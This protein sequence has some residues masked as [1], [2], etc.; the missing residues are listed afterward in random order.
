MDEDAAAE[1]RTLSDHA[2]LLAPLHPLFLRFCS[3]NP[4][5]LKSQG[6]YSGLKAV[7]PLQAGPFHKPVSTA[8]LDLLVT[9]LVLGRSIRWEQIRVR[10]CL[11]VRLS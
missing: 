10:S 6:A 7:H 9:G 11:H 1:A 3:E 5:E 2:F 8:P 4:S